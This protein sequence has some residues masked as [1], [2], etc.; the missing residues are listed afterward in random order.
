M[1]ALLIID[2]QNDFLPDGSLAVTGGHDII[3]LINELMHSYDLVVATQDFHPADHGS[4]AENHHDQAI[5][6]VI[7]LNGLQ[8]ILWPTHCVEGTIGAA[9]ATN[10]NT[11]NIDQI[12]QKGTDPTVDSYSGFFDNGQRKATGL[13]DY[14]RTQNITEL[15]IVGVATDY[16]VKFTALDAIT[17][18][19]QTTLITDA[20]R[21]VNI[22]ENDTANAIEEMKAAGVTVITSDALLSE[23]VTLYRPAGP[24]ELQKLEE[25]EFTAWPP[26][27][28]D[29]PI[30]YPVTNQA[31]AEQIAQEWNIRDSGSGYVTRFEVTRS[32]LT[33][34]P[35]KVVGGR[36]HEELWIPAEDLKDLNKHIVGKIEVVKRYEPT[37]TK[38]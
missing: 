19:F 25:A 13:A 22:Q 21:G 37:P 28:P 9:F 35:R 33:P 6:D 15:H 8:Q 38:T 1:K 7:D 32:F 11:D 29:Q 2:I 17:E 27:L 26:R 23:T 16:C 3:P 14:L 31:Y 18:G 5:G 34:Y 36:Q 20:C 30:F 10:L 24:E 4:F 12:F